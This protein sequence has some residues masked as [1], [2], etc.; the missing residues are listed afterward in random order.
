MLIYNENINMHLPFDFQILTIFAT[1]NVS[2]NKL[3]QY[4]NELKEQEMN[5][6]ESYLLIV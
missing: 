1:I 4:A 5:V 3:N 6:Y 2:M